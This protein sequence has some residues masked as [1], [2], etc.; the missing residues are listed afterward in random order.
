MKSPR[1]AGY[2]VCSFNT[3]LVMVI[4]SV[5]CASAAWS[6]FFFR[7]IFFCIFTNPRRKLI[8]FL[9]KSVEKEVYIVKNGAN[10]SV[11]RTNWRKISV[12]LYIFL[13]VYLIIWRLEVL[14]SREWKWGA[15][16]EVA[17]ISDMDACIFI[18]LHPRDDHTP[19][20]SHFFLQL[21]FFF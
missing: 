10:I 19:I 14:N 11:D 8:D 13:M 6:I 2:F 15:A 7:T 4:K 1:E 17:W 20:L 12:Y 9:K 18:F 5:R 3:Y 21:L 16:D